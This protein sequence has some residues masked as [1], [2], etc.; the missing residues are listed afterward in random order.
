MSLAAIDWHPSRRRTVAVSPL[1]NLSVDERTACS[2]TPFAARVLLWDFG[3]LIKPLLML[4][5]APPLCRPLVSVCAGVLF[6]L[7]C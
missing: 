1:R 7:F 6:C 3:D 5:V 2:G 4:E